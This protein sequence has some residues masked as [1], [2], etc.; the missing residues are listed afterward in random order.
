MDKVGM[1]GLLTVGWLVLG[2]YLVVL[3]AVSATISA[4]AA[5]RAG[6]RTASG[7]TRERAL[8]QAVLR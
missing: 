5:L 2:I 3:L 8:R 4:A 1:G 6:L 7:W